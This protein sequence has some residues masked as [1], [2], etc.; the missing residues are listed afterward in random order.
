MDKA[1][2][3][4]GWA[5]GAGS[6]QPQPPTRGADTEVTHQ[7][8]FGQHW[9]RYLHNLFSLHRETKVTAEKASSSP[10]YGGFLRMKSSSWMTQSLLSKQ[11]TGEPCSAINKRAAQGATCSLCLCSKSWC[12]MR[13]RCWQS[14][15]L[16]ELCCGRSLHRGCLV[17][18][19]CCIIWAQPAEMV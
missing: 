10:I 9:A 17:G 4:L 18:H 6:N 2:S 8:Q 12:W 3:H 15:A 11:G 14:R 1:R 16:W 7:G 5:R 13:R 19:L